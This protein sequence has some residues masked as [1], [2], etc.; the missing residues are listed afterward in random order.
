MILQLFPLR[1]M[2][3]TVADREADA[4]EAARIR[5]TLRRHLRHVEAGV[6]GWNG[7]RFEAR[8]NARLDRQEE[9]R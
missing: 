8:K 5:A 9:A 7:R 6:R 3:G 1:V 4:A 2:R